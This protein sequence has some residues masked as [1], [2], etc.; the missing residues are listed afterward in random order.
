M[1]FVKRDANGNFSLSLS[2]SLTRV[3]TIKEKKPVG[4]QKQ[5]SALNAKLEAGEEVVIEYRN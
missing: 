5:L 3:S 1:S 2:L 4:L